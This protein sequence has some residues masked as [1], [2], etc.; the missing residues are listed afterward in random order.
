MGVLAGLRDREQLANIDL[1]EY[2]NE[3]IPKVS[4]YIRLIYI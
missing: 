3:K 2:V 1:L 4:L